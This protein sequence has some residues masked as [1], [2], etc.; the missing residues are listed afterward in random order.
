M[1][2]HGIHDSRLD[3]G[4]GL[5]GENLRLQTNDPAI[6]ALLSLEVAR[7][8][9]IA[10]ARPLVLAGHLPP[11]SPS[12]LYQIDQKVLSFGAALFCCGCDMY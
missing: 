10:D 11:L 2:W 12:L 7:A 9:T 5:C 6:W 1:T 8:I 4:V 3:S